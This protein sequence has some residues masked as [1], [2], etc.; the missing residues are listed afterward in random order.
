MSWLGVLNFVVL[1]WFGVRLDRI[2]ELR[3]RGIDDL[4]GP[5][6]LHL[7]WITQQQYDR[8]ALHLVTVGYRWI[9]WVWPLSGWWSGY[10][11]I[12]RRP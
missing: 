6:I 9:R 8:V 3:P 10:R 5:V 12:A 2:T 1:Q 4:V 7:G 11:W